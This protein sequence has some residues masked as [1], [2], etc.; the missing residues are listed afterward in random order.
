MEKMM[1]EYMQKM[2]NL[3]DDM[4]E[5]DK[6]RDSQLQQVFKQL[7]VREQGNL[8]ATTEPNPREQLRAITLRS[9][10]ELQDPEVEVNIDEVPV[11]T[12]IGTTPQKQNESTPQ[13]AGKEETSSGQTLPTN[14]AQLNTIPFPT[15]VK[16]NKDE[17]AFQ[18]FLDVIGQVEVKMPLVDVLTEMPK[19]DPAEFCNSV[20]VIKDK[21]SVE[22]LLSLE[23]AFQEPKCEEVCDIKTRSESTN[24]ATSLEFKPLPAHLEYAFLDSEAGSTESNAASSSAPSTLGASSQVSSR[25]AT[26][27]RPTPQATPATTQADPTPEWARR[28]VEQQDTILQRMFEIG[29]QQASQAE[30]FAQLRRTFTSF[31]SDVHIGLTPRSPEGDDPSASVPPPS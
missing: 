5:R 27:R 20:K 19:Y 26:H 15:R 1:M 12:P 22:D 31:Y 7:G 18:K 28:I 9:G 17:K 24:E 29:Q 30:N 4:K 16:K 8:P 13:G 25:R 11:D 2:N 6:T 10:K 3:A 23:I 14:Q 21:G